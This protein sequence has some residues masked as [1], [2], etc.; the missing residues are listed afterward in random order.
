V[1]GDLRQL[2]LSGLV[3]VGGDDANTNAAF[4]AEN[5]QGL[6]T[7]VIGIPKTI[8]G[9]LQVPGLLQI[10]FGFHSACMAFA[11]E[12]GNLTSDCKSDLKYW[13]LNRLMG[14]SASHIA[15]EVAFQTHPNV[16]LVGEEIEENERLANQWRDHPRTRS[17]LTPQS[18]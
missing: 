16:I 5:L 15:L 17:A 2:N 7:Q 1:P 14:R 4:L 9:D 11:T 13:H 10:P 12:V 18:Q 3:V 6:G 8:D